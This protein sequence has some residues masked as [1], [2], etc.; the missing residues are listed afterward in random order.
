MSDPNGSENEGIP[1]DLIGVRIELPTNQP[2]VLLAGN[3][4]LPVSAYLD[5]GR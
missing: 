1:M 2:I 3:G 4:W 5:R